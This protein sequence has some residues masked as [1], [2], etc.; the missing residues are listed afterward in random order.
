MQFAFGF[1]PLPGRGL[2]PLPA[3]SLGRPAVAPAAV[4]QRIAPVLAT[5]PQ[6][7]T[8][9]AKVLSPVA[10]VLPAVA[11]ILASVPDIL[12]TV[13]RV[14]G[15]PALRLRGGGD[16][17]QQCQGHRSDFDMPHRILRCCVSRA[18]P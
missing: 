4:V 3:E 15:N 11:H 10:S 8:A 16:T 6:V 1:F 9:I 2:P 13:P 7:F 12:E 5:V 17:S 18:L 14:T